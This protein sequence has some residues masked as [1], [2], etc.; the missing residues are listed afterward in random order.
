MSRSPFL[1]V[2][3]LPVAGAVLRLS[4]GSGRGAGHREL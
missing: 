4:C 2:E 3:G 1:L